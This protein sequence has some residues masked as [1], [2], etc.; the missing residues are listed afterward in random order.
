M[1]QQ[2]VPID[3]VQ[4]GMFIEDMD[5]PWMDSPFLRHKKKIK[6]EKEIALLKKAGVQVLTI[7]VEKSDVIYQAASESTKTTQATVENSVEA[8]KE[9]KSTEVPPAQSE[10]E[11]PSFKDQLKAAKRL[12]SQVSGVIDQIAEDIANGG[13]INGKALTPIVKESLMLIDQDN[14][15]LLALLHGQRRNKQIQAHSFSVMSLALGFSDLLQIPEELRIALGTGAL[16]HETGWTRLPLNLFLKG[17]AYSENEKKLASQHIPIIAGILKNSPD[18]D[19]LVIKTALQHHA[20]F[21]ATDDFNVASEQG[22]A[23]VLALCNTYDAMI[24]GIGDQAPQVPA[25]AVRKLLMLGKQN[26]FQMSLVTAFI[27]HVGVFPIGSAVVLDDGQKGVVIDIN[28]SNPMKPNVRVWYD[29]QGQKLN[30]A[31]EVSLAD[32]NLSI[33]EAINPLI[34]NNDPYNLLHLDSE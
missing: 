25:T 7:N 22:I 33:Q 27:K 30:E 1:S 13:P 17:K 34:G 28:R 9:S 2:K 31:L 15:A 21:P 11:K 8:S 10:T 29:G 26:K 20:E 19:T 16:L 5:I 3:H 14:Q 6:S 4:I 24:H 32:D 12:Q 18:I 23:Q